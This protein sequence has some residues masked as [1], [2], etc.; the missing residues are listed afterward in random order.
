MLL[1]ALAVAAGW[2]G[3]RAVGGA[4]DVAPPDATPGASPEAALHGATFVTV[5]DLAGVWQLR[6]GDD[7]AWAASPGDPAMWQRVPVPGAWEDA[8]LWGYDG[9]A[10]LRRTFTLPPGAGDGRPLVLRLGRVDDANEVFLN[11]QRIG[12]TGVM[13]P[14]YETAY[15]A[16][17]AYYL[18]ARALRPGVNTLAVRVYDGELSGGI[19]AG[20]VDIAVA[21]AGTA[22]ATSLVADLAGRWRARDGDRPAW[23]EAAFD[24]ATWAEI[25]VPERWESQGYPDLGGFVW[26]RRT[27]R[28]TSVQAAQ[29]LVFVAGAID[30]LDEVFVN[31][32]RI[33]GTGLPGRVE[34]GLPVVAGDEWQQPRAYAV[35]PGVL[36]PGRNVVAVRVYD[37]LV[38]GG[39][40]QGPVG[41]A[42]PAAARAFV[43][44][45]G[46]PTFDGRV[47]GRASP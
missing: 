7:L 45:L 18:P 37:G 39:I 31:G 38:D 44:A 34:N 40:V 9:F 42:T 30:D 47:L 23:R 16:E 19:V 41:L 3:I 14:A 10:W 43:R 17:C 36:R 32:A 8:G 5:V 1:A 11:G 21:A 13:P 33:G 6:L 46:G 29:P 20:P 12:A 26:M 22:P 27:V 35:P 15:Y 25:T 28:L 4:L 2:A 24:D